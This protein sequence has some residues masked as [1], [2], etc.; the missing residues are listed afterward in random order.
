MDSMRDRDET[1]RNGIKT[2]GPIF[3]FQ[4]SSLPP[5]VIMKVGSCSG[6]QKLHALFTALLK[7]GELLAPESD[8]HTGYYSQDS[9]TPLAEG[10]KHR[11]QSCLAEGDTVHSHSDASK[12]GLIDEKAKNAEQ[13]SNTLLF[14]QLVGF[15]V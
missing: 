7:V 5:Y 3:L 9:W 8:S 15:V 11:C 12:S 4:T 13:L 10:G 14:S 1:F 6:F 2:P